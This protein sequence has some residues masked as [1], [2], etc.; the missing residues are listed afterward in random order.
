MNVSSSKYAEYSVPIRLPGCF[1]YLD[2]FICYHHIASFPASP[3]YYGF[4]CK[5]YIKS[6]TFSKKLYHTSL[7]IARGAFAASLAAL[8]RSS[9]YGAVERKLNLTFFAV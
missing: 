6:Q 1:T 9:L 3:I 7:E 2:I 8:R 4:S 5:Y